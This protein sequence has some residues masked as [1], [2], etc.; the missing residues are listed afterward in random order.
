MTR[1]PLTDGEFKVVRLVPHA[2]AAICR[3]I[4][5]RVSPATASADPGLGVPGTEIRQDNY[6]P[7]P[8]LRRPSSENRVYR[9]ACRGGGA[10]PPIRLSAISPSDNTPGSTVATHELIDYEAIVLA[11]DVTASNILPSGVHWNP[12][13]VAP[14]PGPS[15]LPFRRQHSCCPVGPSKASTTAGSPCPTACSVRR[16]IRGPVYLAP[17]IWAP[18]RSSGSSTASGAVFPRRCPAVDVRA[19]SRDLMRRLA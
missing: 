12:D 9:G 19:G 13:R 14:S 1:R 6:R 10:S 18:R 5:G 17:G 16:G 8:G 15:G 2:F 3:P 7:H 4:G 11:D